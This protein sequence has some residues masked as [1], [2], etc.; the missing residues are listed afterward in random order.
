MSSA[1]PGPLP[2][3]SLTV[4]TRQRCHRLPRLHRRL[5]AVLLGGHVTRCQRAVGLLAGN[6]EN[7]RPRLQQ[8]G[9]GGSIA[10]NRD[11]GWYGHF[12]LAALVVYLHNLPLRRSGDLGH[13]RIGHHAVRDEIPRKLAFGGAAHV[14]GKDMHLDGLERA[15]GA[16]DRS[17]G[18]VVSGLD[19]GNALGD[20]TAHGEVRGQGGRPKLSL[21]R[22]GRQGIAVELV[23]C[24]ANAHRRAF[25]RGLSQGRQ[26][27]Q[28]DKAG[29][30]QRCCAHD[31]PSPH[32]S[33][34]VMT[35]QRWHYS[36]SYAR[37]FSVTRRP[38]RATIID[39]I[40]KILYCLVRIP[41][42]A[43]EGILG[44]CGVLTNW[45]RNMIHLSI[46]ML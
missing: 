24:A 27:K 45:P 23:D 7:R 2:S 36:A 4:V 22:F 5:D 26:S 28:R 8:A 21:A 46:A 43:E 44:P 38:P 6:D 18:D 31:L 3:S 41:R 11:A 42:D 35:R 39:S 10:D 34:M 32:S 14:L 16:F 33:L 29:G 25:R 30:E 20:D 40:A 13:R 15:G 17:R 12:G 37:H 9:V 1:R 19:V